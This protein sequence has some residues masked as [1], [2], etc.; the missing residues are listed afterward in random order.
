MLTPPLPSRKFTPCWP[1]WPASITGCLARSPLPAA[2]SSSSSSSSSSLRTTSHWPVSSSFH[3]DDSPSPSLKISRVTV[4]LCTDGKAGARSEAAILKGAGHR[5]HKG[6]R[7]PR[8]WVCGVV[9]LW[10]QGKLLDVDGSCASTCSTS[11]M[12][13]PLPLSS[14]SSPCAP[15]LPLI[16][17]R[18]RRG[19]GFAKRNRNFCG[20]Q[21]ASH[22]RASPDHWTLDTSPPHHS[23]PRGSSPGSR[24]TRQRWRAQC[25][26]TRV[27][28]GP[29]GRLRQVLSGR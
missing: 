4:K 24:R 20:A 27:C 13:P 15:N 18:H 2:T 21:N 16:P 29:V 19:G 14:C 26:G 11:M 8:Q 3:T 5:M 17:I 25:W 12:M 7:P 28:L 1:T 6:R 23:R 9:G 10:R 22:S